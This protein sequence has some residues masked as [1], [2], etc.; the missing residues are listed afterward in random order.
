LNYGEQID[1][2][3]VLSYVLVMT[4]I[5]F[6]NEEFCRLRLEAEEK[7]KEVKKTSI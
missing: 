3:N 2:I 6:T 5:T 1:F 7:Y 4:K